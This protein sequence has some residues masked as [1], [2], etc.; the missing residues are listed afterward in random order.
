[1]IFLHWKDDPSLMNYLSFYL[2]LALGTFFKGVPMVGVVL[3]LILPVA[4][5]RGKLK[6][7]FCFSNL[8]ALLTGAAIVLLPYI[9]TQNAVS[10]AVNPSA[11]SGIEMFWNNQVIRILDARYSGEPV[12]SYLYHLPRLLFPWSVVFVIAVAGF[13][14]IR[15]EL[16]REFS[17]LLS[18]MGMAFGLFCFSGSRRW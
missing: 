2:M 10:S 13:I 6:Q 1:M 14:K 11:N 3:L 8:F 9:F 16:N 15:K 12:Y 7:Y 4:A 17:A 5:V 18:G